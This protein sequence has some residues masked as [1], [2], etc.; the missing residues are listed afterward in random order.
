M[1]LN[2]PAVP[3]NGM[4]ISRARISFLS[5]VGLGG[6]DF[7]G[8]RAKALSTITSTGR[9]TSRE[10]PRILEPMDK[11]DLWDTQD[12]NQKKSWCSYVRAHWCLFEVSRFSVFTFCSSHLD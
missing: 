9:S 6:G 2:F 4:P 5:I 11:Q 7:C 3:S 8:S 1:A 10:P 12:R